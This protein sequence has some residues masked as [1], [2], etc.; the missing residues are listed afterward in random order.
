MQWMNC[1]DCHHQFINGHFTDEALEVIFSKQP[2]EQVVGFEVAFI[3]FSCLEVI[4]ML[5]GSKFHT[6]VPK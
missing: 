1:E 3:N 6:N 2:E 5:E 4:W